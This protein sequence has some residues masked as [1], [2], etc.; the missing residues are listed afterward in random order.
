M[1]V[2]YIYGARPVNLPRS[3]TWLLTK[4]GGSNNILA[5]LCRGGAANT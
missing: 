1:E 5:E 2:S 3:G 4:S